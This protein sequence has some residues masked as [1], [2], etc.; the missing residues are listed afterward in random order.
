MTVKPTVPYYIGY[1]GAQK[2]NVNGD[3]EY[4]KKDMDRR[5]QIAYIRPVD[6][7]PTANANIFEPEDVWA[8]Y[9]NALASN[10]IDIKD[11]G[12]QELK[13]VCNVLTTAGETFTNDYGN[14]DLFSN[15]ENSASSGLLSDVAQALNIKDVGKSLVDFG[16]TDNFGSGAAS[17]LGDAITDIDNKLQSWSKSNNMLLSSA[18]EFLRTAASA[19]TKPAAKIDFPAFWKGSSYQCQYEISTSLY[20]FDVQNDNEY[21]SNIVASYAALMQFVLPRSEDGKMYTWPFLMSFRI[22]GII[23]I[24]FGYMSNISVIKG[25]D[26]N[27]VSCAYRPNSI[28]LKMI[29]SPLYEVMQNITN[30]DENINVTSDNS[31]PTLLREINTLSE[32]RKDNQ[33]EVD[34]SSTNDTNYSSSNVVSGSGES[35]SVRRKPTTLEEIYHQTLNGKIEDFRS[36]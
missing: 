4:F 22:P 19:Y 20:C 17:W 29:I 25:G 31:R 34:Y 8:N 14:S 12:S 32:I 11:D 6:I 15:F 18:S 30:K 28:E 13:V 1:P 21:L 24:P 2:Y 3:Y 16:K 36:Y 10:G 7:H 27:D 5:F 26:Q 35:Q 23:N 33:L 9:T